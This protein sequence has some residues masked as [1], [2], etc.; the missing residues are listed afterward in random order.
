[1]KLTPRAPLPNVI[2][3]FHCR[4][5][6]EI[7]FFQISYFCCPRAS[8]PYHPSHQKS[9]CNCV[10][11]RLSEHLFNRHS[12]TLAFTALCSFFEEHSFDRQ[13]DLSGLC[14][15]SIAI[16]CF[17]LA[18]VVLLK[19]TGDCLF[20]KLMAMQ[21]IQKEVTCNLALS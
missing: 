10:T 2:T 1:M 9:Y 16:Y 12:L 6:K 15:T 20:K 13:G 14:Y 3:I 7:F 5:I 17:S 8:I 4:H 19:K 18:K 21:Q 11:T